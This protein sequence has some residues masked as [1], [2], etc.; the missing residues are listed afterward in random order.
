MAKK[1]TKAT[2]KKPVIREVANAKPLA[3]NG[4]F[5]EAFKVV[6]KHKEQQKKP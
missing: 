1:E 2:K 5:L 6:K 3:I 4:D